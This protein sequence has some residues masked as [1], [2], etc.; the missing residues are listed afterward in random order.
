MRLP[1][2][3]SS[4]LP[5]D[6][7]LGAAL[8][9]L[10]RAFCAASKPPR[11]GSCRA[12]GFDCFGDGLE[13]RQL[14]DAAALMGARF[15]ARCLD[16][17]LDLISSSGSF[18][19]KPAISGLGHYRSVAPRA[20]AWPRR[21]AE[22]QVSSDES[23]PVF[24]LTRPGAAGRASAPKATLK[25]FM[26]PGV[27]VEAF[28]TVPL[29]EPARSGTANEP[30][31]RSLDDAARPQATHACPLSRQSLAGIAQPRRTGHHQYTSPKVR[32]AT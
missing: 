26:G 6:L 29:P 25:C 30:Q 4:T 13:A 11:W 7:L 8:G 3:P 32:A 1:A 19:V 2:A 12:L 28:N 20:Q 24:D 5:R 10:T 27:A 23:G 18:P 22:R 9:S 14:I 16:S 21:A 17:D 31:R 15:R